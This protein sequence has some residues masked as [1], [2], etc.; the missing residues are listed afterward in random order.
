MESHLWTDNNV[1]CNVKIR[2]ER[3]RF[4]LYSNRAYSEL[5]LGVLF[6]FQFHQPSFTTSLPVT[7]VHIAKICYCQHFWNKA[8]VRPLKCLADWLSGRWLI[9]NHPRPKFYELWAGGILLW[10]PVADPDISTALPRCPWARHWA[11]C[12]WWLSY[13]VTFPL[14]MCVD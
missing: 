9:C 1:T 3:G 11:P 4:S 8:S 5:R 2:V 6:K 12:P 14:L 7:R 10:V 13:S